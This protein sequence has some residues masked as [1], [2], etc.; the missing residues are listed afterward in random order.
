MALTLIVLCLGSW[1]EFVLRTLHRTT[2]PLRKLDFLFLLPLLVH[3]RNLA[4]FSSPGKNPFSLPCAPA[5][6]RRVWARGFLNISA[7]KS[8]SCL[9]LGLWIEQL[10]P[11]RCNVLLLLHASHPCAEATTL[12]PQRLHPHSN[13][14]LSPQHKYSA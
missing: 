2:P 12:H 13:T 10:R 7:S 11:L 14:A 6:R 1:C 9:R 8:N 3:R 4:Q 5:L